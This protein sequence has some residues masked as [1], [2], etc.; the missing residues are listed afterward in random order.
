MNEPSIVHLPRGF[1]FSSVACGIKSSGKPDVAVLIADQPCSTYGAFTQ[2]QVRASS[3]DWNEQR[4][5]HG[6]ALVINSGNANACTGVQGEQDTE[7]MAKLLAEQISADANEVFVMSTGIIG[8]KMP[9]A[10]VEKGIIEASIKASHSEQH[11]HDFAKGIMTT[12]SFPKIQSCQFQ[13]GGESFTILGI[14]KGAGMIGPRMATMLCVIVTDFPLA[15]GGAKGTSGSWQDGHQRF[16]G[17]INRTFNSISVDGHTSTSDQVLL[18]APELDTNSDSADI[19]NSQPVFWDALEGVCTD[20]A[21]MIP[22]D[23]E[24]ATH[25]IN[26]EVTGAY[27]EESLR[28]VAK[29]IADSP[30]VKT[31]VFGGDPNWGRI[32]SAAGYNGLKFDPSQTSLR[33]NDYLLF[34]NGSPVKFDEAE[35]SRSMKEEFETRIVLDLGGSSDADTRFSATYWTSDL[36]Y[37][38]VKINA[39]YH[40]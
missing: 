4:V 36:T 23:G 30:L 32:V 17:I 6:K 18:F 9:M 34:Q 16:M 21:K 8:E 11:V 13:I 5:G 40:T 35:V 19:L 7:T 28:S 12:D 20:L 22:S 14:A 26:I 37:D 2:N 38:Y 31:A 15:A 27:T 33:V 24:G 3:V 29:T 25:L 10:T 1:Q 39:E